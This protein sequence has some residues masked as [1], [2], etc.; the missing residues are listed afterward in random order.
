MAERGGGCISPAGLGLRR[1]SI[2]KKKIQ[3]EVGISRTEK[4][5]RRE[6][7]RSNRSHN[8]RDSGNDRRGQKK[9]P[10][11]AENVLGPD[12]SEKLGRQQ[13]FVRGVKESLT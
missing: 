7:G 10:A 6:T 4:N 5:L 11:A 13:M 3:G 9:G 1:A 12:N 8:G 2:A